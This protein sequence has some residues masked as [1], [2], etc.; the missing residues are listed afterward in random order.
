MN[1]ASA[2]SER[3]RLCR[4]KAGLSQQELAQAAG[5][6][7]SLVAKLEQ[8]TKADPRVSSLMALAYGLGVTPGALLDGLPL[9]RHEAQETIPKKASEKKSKAK[10]KGKK[11]K[12]K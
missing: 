5:L 4:E 11:K 8:G 6:S 9:S 1:L 2:L 10:D 3:I 7:L 12:K